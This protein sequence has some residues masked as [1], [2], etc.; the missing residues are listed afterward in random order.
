MARAKVIAMMKRKAG[1]TPEEFRNYY[2]GTHAPLA[3][4]HFSEFFADYRRNY[5]SMEFLVD[6]DTS[7]N[8]LKGPAQRTQTGETTYD[9]ITEFWYHDKQ[10]MDAMFAK[11]G[12]VNDI[13]VVD[14]A[15]FIDRDT[16]RVFIVEES[17]SDMGG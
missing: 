7:G 11:F 12:E 16:L 13:F 14:E 9:V 10:A 8:A 17:A 3:M 2:E 1:V 6:N 5:P 15:E 4:K